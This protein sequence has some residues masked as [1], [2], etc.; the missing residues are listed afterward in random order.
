[1]VPILLDDVSFW[2]VVWWM[3]MVFFWMMILWAFIV[4]FGDI[5][6]RTDLSGWAKAGW[7]FLI[8]ILPFIGILIYMIARPA[9]TPADVAYQPQAQR[10]SGYSATE[11]IAKAQALLQSG[12]ITQ[13]EFDTIKQ[14]ALG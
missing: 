14:R 7:I 1:M 2:D 12:A 11:E 13:Q 4:V 8:F 9:S 5:L 3:L 10:A 6:R